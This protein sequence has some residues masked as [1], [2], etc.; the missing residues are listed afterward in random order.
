MLMAFPP[1]YDAISALK[2]EDSYVILLSPQGKTLKQNL[3]KKLVKHK[4]IILICGHYEGVDARILSFV[5]LEV[6]I[7]DYVLTQG[8]LP[9]M[10]L[11]DSIIRLCG[12][13]I[14]NSSVT[15]DSCYEGILK[16]DEYTKPE[17]YLGYKVPEILLSGHHENIKQYN[18]YEALKNT[19]LKRP[20]LLRRKKLNKVDSSYL[21]QIKEENKKK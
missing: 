9:A 18:R 4:H 13:V 6:S 5:D 17:D 12:G 7:G 2:T 14:A 19:Y 3:C 15:S 16:E 21:L 20:E 10:V 1:L 8:E 11:M